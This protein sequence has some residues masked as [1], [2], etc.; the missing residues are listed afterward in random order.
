M[1]GISCFLTQGVVIITQSH[2]LP[3][4]RS[5]NS[6]DVVLSSRP[7][8]DSLRVHG[9]RLASIFSSIPTR[10]D[11]ARG[12]CYGFLRQV[13]HLL[14][15]LL[16]PRNKLWRD[17][18]QTL[19]RT[20]LDNLWPARAL[21]ANPPRLVKLNYRVVCN[22]GSVKNQTCAVPHNLDTTPDCISYYA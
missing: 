17:H 12:G 14:C 1:D 8:I 10:H 15:A 20:Q 9:R 22:L 21:H 13:T 2:L 11:E 5:Y 7:E 4:R 19:S 16:D 3:D 18:R 6:F